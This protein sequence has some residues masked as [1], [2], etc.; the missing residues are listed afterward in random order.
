MEFGAWNMVFNS[1][2]LI[3][4][5]R[6]FSIFIGKIFVPNKETARCVLE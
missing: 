1:K 4:I 2:S 3:S 6:D 5:E